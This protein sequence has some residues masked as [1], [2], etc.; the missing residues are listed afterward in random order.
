[1]DTWYQEISLFPA[2]AVSQ[3]AFSPSSGHYSQM[4]WA[5]TSRLGCGFTEFP[6]GRFLARLL[7]CNYGTAGNVINTPMYNIGP[8]CTVCP[9]ATSCS[10]QYPG[11]CSE[12]RADVIAPPPTT[13]LA[14]PPPPSTTPAVQ[15]PT[16]STTE[17][18]FLPIF[19]PRNNTSPSPAVSD[20][21]TVVTSPAQVVS[22]RPVLVLAPA[23]VPVT[24]S[25]QGDNSFF[26]LLT[27]GP[28]HMLSMASHGVMDTAHH[29][30]HMGHM[31]VSGVTGI[32][33]LFFSSL[34]G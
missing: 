1:M 30:A 34:L 11:L 5:Q 3:Y 25:C 20:P 33:N 17:R 15:F 13:T 6:R 16:S 4:V 21:T 32:P 23:P 18:P 7:V 26:C 28:R 31:V 27:T 10:G 14:P 24:P 9:Q 22:R 29:M 2:N 19:F 8:A 12:A